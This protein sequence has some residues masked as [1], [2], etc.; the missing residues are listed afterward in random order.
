MWSAAAPIEPMPPPQ[1]KL[2][3]GQSHCAPTVPC[4]AMAALLQ[5][6]VSLDRKMA[7]AAGNAT[8]MTAQ[9]SAA[10]VAIRGCAQL[11]DR[12]PL[13]P[14]DLFRL[15]SSLALIFGT[16]PTVLRHVS[17]SPEPHVALAQLLTCSQQLVAAGE[18]LQRAAQ[19]QQTEAAAAFCKTAG[20]PQTVLP[21]LLEVSQMLLAVPERLRSAGSQLNLG[22]LTPQGE[23]TVC[24]SY[25]RQQRQPGCLSGWHLTFRASIHCKWFER[26]WRVWSIWKGYTCRALLPPSLRSYVRQGAG[27]LHSCGSH[28][29]KLPA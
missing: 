22:D 18:V 9:F 12:L 2:A 20:R 1:G 10:C 7:S 3:S 28:P 19:P 6:M 29:V 16:G 23:C 26:V 15:G 8:C 13:G 4:S 17:G 24:A 21:W 25:V 5:Q 14:N 27:Q 11:S